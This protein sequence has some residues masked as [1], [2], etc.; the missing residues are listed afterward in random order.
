MTRPLTEA[1]RSALR[2]RARHAL[3]RRGDLSWK[4]TPSSLACSQAFDAAPPRATFVDESGR[5][6]GKSY[7]AIC[8]GLETLIRNPGQ[9]GN[10]AV[11][12]GKA[13]MEIVVPILAEIA[14]DAPPELM[15][16]YNAQTGHISFPKDGPAD[17][18]F[19]MLFGCEDVHKADRARGPKSVINIIEEAAFIPI[20]RYVMGEILKPQTANTKA[21]TLIVSS[22]PVS[23]GHEFC[24][25]ADAAHARGFYAHRNLYSPGGLFSSTADADEYVASFAADMGYS[26]ED[27]RKTA[28]Y[29]REVLGERC[30]DERL[31][32]VP[33]FAEVEKEVV[34]EHPRPAG[35][36]L[37]HAYVSMDPGMSD[38][39]GVLFAYLDFTAGGLVVI[40][41][42]L[43]L[44]QANTR[45]IAE[46][47]AAKEAEL[48]PDKQPYLRVV[49]DPQQRLV[50]DLSNEHQLSFSPARKDNV[51]EAINLLRLVVGSRKL[52]VHPRCK[53]TVR[54]LRNAVR[55]KPGGDMARS[56]TDGHYDLV[57]AA[58]YLTRHVERQRNPYPLGWDASPDAHWVGGK[59][60]AAASPL[61]QAL[62]GGSAIGRR[63][64][65]NG[66]SGR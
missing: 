18:A 39:T 34:R 6:V 28:A 47:I 41:D 38:K 64:L 20:L 24:D 56:E 10:Y 29:K 60:K 32:V 3:W 49:D 27:F 40:E 25:I 33:E 5:K 62:L 14:Q 57:A 42:E 55:T 37:V 54:Q 58:W 50:A 7:W 15:P 16:A 21:K 31:A 52:V 63:L 9:R 35:F 22:P 1:Q 46:A 44:S 30:I 53:H 65:R 11:S 4:L 48:W 2:L 51:E 8:K 45:T 43:L 36:H 61:S 19:L 12:T 59:P 26:L 13:A 23:P 17:G 66:R